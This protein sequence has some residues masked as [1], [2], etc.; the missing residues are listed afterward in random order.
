MW[1]YRSTLNFK[2][3]VGFQVFWPLK[4]WYFIWHVLT[5]TPK[6]VGFGQF[7]WPD[8]GD[9]DSVD[10]LRVV[11]INPRTTHRKMVKNCGI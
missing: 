9:I 6:A 4:L 10:R 5:R 8:I 7:V 11:E 3:V 1:P 2:Q